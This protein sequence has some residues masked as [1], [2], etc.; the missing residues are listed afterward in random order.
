MENEFRHSPDLLLG[1]LMQLQAF[2]GNQESSSEIQQ[3]HFPASRDK[4]CFNS[5]EEIIKLYLSFQV[6]IQFPMP[7]EFKRKVSQFNSLKSWH[8]PTQASMVDRP[9]GGRFNT[10]NG[11]ILAKIE[12]NSRPE[13]LI[14][15]LPNF[16][17]IQS[18]SFH[19]RHI[20]TLAS[21]DL[22]LRYQIK[23]ERT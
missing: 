3:G 21:A 2:C 8:S 23:V 9:N 1:Q 6:E 11:H 14:N 5:K 18:I 10:R 12:R 4:N 7:S 20:P 15:E 19:F 22:L 16:Y 13:T 17:K